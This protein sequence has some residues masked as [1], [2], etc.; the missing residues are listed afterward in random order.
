MEIEI[1]GVHYLFRIVVSIM[2]IIYSSYAFSIIWFNCISFL[3]L[4]QKNLRWYHSSFNTRI[5][6]VSQLELEEYGTRIL[7]MYCSRCIVS[8]TILVTLLKLR[9]KFTITHRDSSIEIED[10]TLKENSK[11]N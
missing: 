3:I 5:C 9:V 6:A 2:C 11:K 4:V 10:E 1:N 8:E 7:Y